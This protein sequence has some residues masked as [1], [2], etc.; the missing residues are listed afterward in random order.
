MF[1]AIKRFFREWEINMTLFE[2]VEALEAT[3]ASLVTD[4][5]ALKAAPAGVDN[6]AAIAAVEAEVK[7]L[8][9]L[10]GTPKA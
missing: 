7:A 10:V 2:R 3:S 9:A 5:A 6:T 4:V 1:N 8:A